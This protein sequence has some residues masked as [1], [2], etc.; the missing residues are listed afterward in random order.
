MQS[1][2]HGKMAR[3][4]MR[5]TVRTAQDSRAVRIIYGSSS[6]REISAQEL[7]EDDNGAHEQSKNIGPE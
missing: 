6:H 5:F 2:L 4:Q 1:R 7:S 3:G